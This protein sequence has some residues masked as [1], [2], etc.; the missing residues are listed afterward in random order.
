[1]V[2]V[3]ASRYSCIAI[4]WVSLMSF[5]AITLY[6]VSQRMFNV[7]VDDFVIDWLRKRL[8]TPSYT[9]LWQIDHKHEVYYEDSNYTL[10]SCINYSK[11]LKREEI[12]ISQCIFY[13]QTMRTHFQQVIN[14]IKEFRFPMHILVIDYEK[15]YGPLNQ[16]KKYRKMSK[17]IYEHI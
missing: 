3:S 4:L 17:K 16:K 12:S 11:L 7:V 6:V 14:K 10:L 9:W 5:A 1:M 2:Q 8:D 13:S 15:A